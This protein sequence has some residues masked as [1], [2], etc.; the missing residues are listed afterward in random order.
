MPGGRCDDAASASPS[1][2]CRY[3]LHSVAFVC[4]IGFFLSPLYF[5]AEI[6][7]WLSGTFPNFIL[8]TPSLPC[9]L[10]A[11]MGKRFRRPLVKSTLNPTMV[12]LLPTERR[13]G[14][15]LRCRFQSHNGAIAAHQDQIGH[16]TDHHFQSHNGAIAACL[17]ERRRPRFAFNPTMVRLLRRRRP[18]CAGIRRTFNPT[19]VRLLPVSMLLLVAL[20]VAFNPTMVRLLPRQNFGV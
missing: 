12:R 17:S 15:D 18:S 16:G 7:F 1:L 5:D 14:G 3:F 20:V 19:M 11:S 10:D 13:N 2:S 9:F 4:F 8:P 6:A